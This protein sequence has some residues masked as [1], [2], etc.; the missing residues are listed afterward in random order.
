MTNYEEL[1]KRVESGDTAYGLTR[2][3]GKA[4][5][6]SIIPSFGSFSSPL[7]RALS[8]DTD[9]ALDLVPDGQHWEMFQIEDDVFFNIQRKGEWLSFAASGQA[10]TPARAIIAALIRMKGA[11]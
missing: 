7:D 8:N 3:V 5:N 2:E 4:L 11:E 6:V 10:P 9:E 1:A